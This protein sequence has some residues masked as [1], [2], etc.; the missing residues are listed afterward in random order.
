M[1]QDRLATGAGSPY[2]ASMDEA[3][4]LGLSLLGHSVLEGIEKNT[5]NPQSKVQVNKKNSTQYIVIY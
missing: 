4:Q 3:E 5:R 1:N 2:N